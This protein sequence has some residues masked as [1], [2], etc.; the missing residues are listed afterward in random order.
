MA[1]PGEQL[2]YVDGAVETRSPQMSAYAAPQPIKL[3]VVTA[4]PPPQP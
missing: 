1:Q 4:A 3:R 2:I